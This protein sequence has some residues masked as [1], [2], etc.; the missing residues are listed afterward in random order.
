ML[1]VL[2]DILIG[3]SPIVM[4]LALEI[5]VLIGLFVLRTPLELAIVILIPFNIL[6]V[7]FWLPS[8][9]PIMTILTGLVIAFGLL[10]I[11]RR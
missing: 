7:S 1:M 10:R 6:V 5:A 8:L 3:S 11:V 9:I 4:G 2:E